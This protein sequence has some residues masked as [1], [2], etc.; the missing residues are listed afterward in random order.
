MK[1][2]SNGDDFLKTIPPPAAKSLRARK[3]QIDLDYSTIQTVK[4]AIILPQ[5]SLMLK[6]VKYW[7]NLKRQ[8]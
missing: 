1:V 5:V 3:E 2:P 4:E 8:D 7:I 6:S